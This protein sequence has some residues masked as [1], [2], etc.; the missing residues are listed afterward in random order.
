MNKYQLY[1]YLCM[2]LD[3]IKD[4]TFQYLYEC[5]ILYKQWSASEFLTRAENIST[6]SVKSRLKFVFAN[7]SAIVECDMDW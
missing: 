6:V 4:K 5:I 1:R 2:Y 7:I 3:G